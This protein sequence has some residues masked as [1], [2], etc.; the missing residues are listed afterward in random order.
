MTIPSRDP[1]TDRLVGLKLRTLKPGDV[2]FSL[3]LRNN[4]IVM[5]ANDYKIFAENRSVGTFLALR[6]QP[7]VRL[8]IQ[9]GGTT[10]ILTYELY[11]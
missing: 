6:N 4:D 2:L 1:A 9:R 3:G 8:K 11:D 10:R 5:S 7:E